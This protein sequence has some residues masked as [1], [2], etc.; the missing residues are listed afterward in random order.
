MRPSG[1]SKNRKYLFEYQLLLKHEEHN[2]VARV[3][4][5]PVENISGLSKMFTKADESLTNAFWHWIPGT[6]YKH[7]SITHTVCS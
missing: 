7:I 4:D 1:N 3:K 5:R 2:C 6:L